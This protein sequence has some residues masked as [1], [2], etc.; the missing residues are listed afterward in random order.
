VK[1]FT[2]PAGEKVVD[3][4]QNLVGWVVIKIKGNAGDSI[5]LSH[6]EVMDKKGNFYTDNLRAAKAENIYIL[7]GG[8]E[9]S[10]EPHF[11]WQGFRYARIEGLKTDIKAEDIKA[12]TLYSDMK[13]TGSFI[14]SNN[15]IN[16]LQKNIVWGQ[17]GNF[18]D[19]PTDC[20]QRDERLGWTGDAQAFSRTASFN[21]N[22]NNF[23]AKWLRDLEADQVNGSVPFVVPNV[24]NSSISSAGWADVATI[25][26]WNMYLA[27]GDKRLLMTQYG[28]M[29]NYV[30][31][32]SRSAKDYLWNTGFHFGDW[33]FYRPDDDNDGRAAVTDKYLI[34]QC[35]YAHSHTAADQCSQGVG[36][37]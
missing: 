3:F 10:F 5:K 18:L 34:A 35:F 8:Q 13:T 4:G 12:V 1:I 21:M 6:A 26:P 31:Q 11:T 37:E 36:K 17:K 28:S 23:F 29:K 19:V 20:P 25:A 2:T 22:V 16:Q 33:L 24:L 7:K 32:I 14:S 27:Y 9:E 15:L 30:D